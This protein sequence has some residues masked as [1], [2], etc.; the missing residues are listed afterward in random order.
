MFSTEFSLDIFSRGILLE[1]VS[2][3]IPPEISL[4]VF[5]RS[6]PRRVLLKILPRELFSEISPRIL[7]G[8]S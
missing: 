1:S 7:E 3:T 6:P 8:I 2:R 4:F 5:F